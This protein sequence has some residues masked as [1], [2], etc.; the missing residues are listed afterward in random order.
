MSALSTFLAEQND[1][2]LLLSR[3]AL[4]VSQEAWDGEA[5]AVAAVAAN[6]GWH[7]SQTHKETGAIALVPIEGK[8]SE[9]VGEIVRVTR[10][11]GSP[12]PRS[13]LVYVYARID[14]D[15]DMTITRRAFQ[16][17]GLLANESIEARIERLT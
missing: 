1:L 16:E 4:A 3:R 8:F 15:L 5:R 2:D 7:G 13:V 12:A 9:L 17:L 11:G 14:T 6:I 10:L